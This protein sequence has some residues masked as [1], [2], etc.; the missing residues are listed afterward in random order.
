MNLDYDNDHF[1]VPQDLGLRSSHTSV[2][3]LSSKRPETI[4]IADD[5]ARF[6]KSLAALLAT[7]NYLC[8]IAPDGFVAKEMI[9]TSDYDLLIS[10]IQMPGNLG[11]E[12]VRSLPKNAS[13]LPVIL[14][15]AHP[16]IQ[17]AMESVR[18]PIV[19]YLE[20]PPDIDEMFLLIRKAISGYRVFQTVAAKRDR[21]AEYLLDLESIQET[22]RT[23]G[24][25]AS[26]EAYNVLVT[27]TMRNILEA[28]M[29]LKSLN[30][31]LVSDKSVSELRQQIEDTRPFKLIEAVKETIITLEQTKSMFRSKEL[32]GLRRKLEGL[33][34]Q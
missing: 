5:D 1:K 4:L 22:L 30:E 27:L 7:R 33:V 13:G 10:D 17:T 18:L 12:L 3:P 11:L 2:L 21:C 34:K 6:A 14:M 8:Q 24:G 32:A 28:L 15:T 20:K 26:D 9:S 23:T 16:S 25:K 19:A 31:S 29:D